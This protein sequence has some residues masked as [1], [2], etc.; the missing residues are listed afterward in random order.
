MFKFKKKIALTL[1]EVLVVSVISV[2][3]LG[4][5]YLAYSNISSLNKVEALEG[6]F[7]QTSAV[8]MKEI[9]SSVQNAYTKGSV[10]YVINAKKDYDLSPVISKGIYDPSN[11]CD[12]IG[13]FSSS[14]TG[15]Q[16]NDLYKTYIRYGLKKL[17]NAPGTGFKGYALYKEVRE[18]LKDT[19]VPPS[20]DAN[21]ANCKVI[22]GYY[23]N[24]QNYLAVS[25]LNFELKGKDSIA[26]SMRLVGS[27]SRGAG[28]P[29]AVIYK[30]SD[31]TFY[32]TSVQIKVDKIR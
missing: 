1:V 11:S 8:F 17:P 22:M 5:V 18:N 9:T 13:M 10:F 15:Y 20:P 7:K 29:A 28:R 4:V 14:K 31:T 30:P 16:G 32:T 3:V 26:I 24:R 6:E 2:L 23:K 12:T 19:T 27:K 25:K 21:S